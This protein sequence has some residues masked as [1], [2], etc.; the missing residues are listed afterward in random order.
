MLEYTWREKNN[1]MKYLLLMTVSGSGLFVGY[2]CWE[3]ILDKSLT[4]CIKYRA[5]MVVMLVYAIPWVWLR[6]GYR[7][8]FG[9]FWRVGAVNTAK[10]LVNIADIKTEEVAYQT[11]EYR[12]WM[13]ML[14]IWFVIA[15]VIML[16]RVAKY[17][18][19]TNSLRALA[20]EC[21]DKNLHETMARLRESVGYRYKPEV[22]WT[23]VDNETF[24]IGIIK[25]VI[26]LQKKCNDKE[27]YW[28]LKHEM[29]HIVRK[30]LWIKLFLEF[31]CCLHWFNP[32]IYLLERKMRFLCETSCDE[33]VIMG[34]TEDEC[35]AYIELL[36]ANKGGNKLRIPF[37]S[38][39]ED[40]GGEIEKRIALMIERRYTQRRQKATA[41][42]VFGLL[43]F[44]NSL[45][46]LAYPKVYH[47]KIGV[48]ETAEDS[49]GG[50]NFWVD[51]CTKGGYG[52][53]SDTILYEEQFVDEND[54]IYVVNSSDKV[55]VCLVHDK[56]LGVVQVHMKDD[57]GCIIEI[58][59]ANR[60]TKCGMVWKGEMIYK[61]RKIPCPH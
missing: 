55:E 20:I 51:D 16:I 5:L 8:L 15:I 43:V 57:E 26:F 23:R 13:L 24:T 7:S 56:M 59:E 19:K 2:L 50:G 41:I 45:T 49:L 12:L 61:A 11:E 6:E 21:G 18:V 58:Y 17:L 47:V 39:L 52:M 31:V 32:F 35:K 48:I 34:C 4:Q 22:A 28:I 40:G 44:L 38:A 46:A 29:I 30:D 14:A 25:P 42:C 33:R 36:D 60:C 27:L 54:Q 37:S 1:K 9:P 3:R 53:F 10:G